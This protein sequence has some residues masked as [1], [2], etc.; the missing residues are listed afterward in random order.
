[1]TSPARS[2][3]T[4]APELSARIQS[5]P[6]AR[7]LGVEYLELKRGYCRV[8]LTLTPEMLNYQGYP[9]GGVIF[10]LA[11]IAFGAACN[12]HGEPAVAL[13]MTI[14]FLAAVRPGSR[15]VAEGRERKQ[16]RR[17]GFYDIT[18]STAGGV[19]V[20]VVHCVAHRI[21]ARSVSGEET[22]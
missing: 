2:P 19:L 7:A 9:H 22:R 12:S 1:M 4:V 11:D 14:S 21:P 3:S 15:L 8:A 16:G 5:E 10:S 17:A 18:V 6:W 20:A 13:S